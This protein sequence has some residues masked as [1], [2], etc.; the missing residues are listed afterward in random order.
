MLL[1]MGNGKRIVVVVASTAAERQAIARELSLG[2][3]VVEAEPALARAAIA[4][5]CA[6]VVAERGAGGEAL[7]R[8]LA[9]GPPRVLLGPRDNDAQRLEAEGAAEACL[10]Q[11]WRRGQLASTLTRLL[12]AKRRPAVREVANLVDREP[13]APRTPEPREP[14]RHEPPRREPRLREVSRQRERPATRDASKPSPAS[15]LRE[16]LATLRSQAPR[17][18]LGLAAGASASEARKA[19]LALCK[20]RHPDRYAHEDDQLKRLATEVFVTFERALA[21]IK[22]EGAR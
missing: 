18:V 14:R 2:F 10:P 3:E 16:E 21:A 22:A 13:I 15:E 12:H 17:A 1:A 20:T 6:A 5:G 8:E 19:F 4:R 11:P 9:G 7:L